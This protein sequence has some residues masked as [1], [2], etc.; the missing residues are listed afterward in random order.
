M[1]RAGKYDKAMLLRSISMFEVVELIK[2]VKIMISKIPPSGYSPCIGVKMS[3][4]SI[5]V[6]VIG[7]SGSAAG[8]IAF[9]EQFLP[10][11]W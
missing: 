5:A 6:I 8:R 4:P 10:S 9:A 7:M 3:S 2:P 1:T 11:H